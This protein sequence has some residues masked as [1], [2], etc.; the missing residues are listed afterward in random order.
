MAMKAFSSKTLRV[1]GILT[2]IIIIA[3]FLLFPVFSVLISGFKDLSGF[4]EIFSN[5]LYLQIFAFTIG[6]ALLSTLITLIIGIPIGYIFGKYN[7]R[8]RKFFLTLFTVPFI[9]PSV[10]VGMGFLVMFGSEGLFNVPLLSIILAHAFYNIPL[11]VQYFSAYY[12]NFNRS[13]VDAA[14]TLGSNSFNTMMRIYLPIFLQPILT[15]AFL[16][17]NFSFLSFGVIQLLSAGKIATIETLIYSNF[18]NFGVSYAA[19]LAILQLLVVLAYIVIYLL[20]MRTNVGKEKA[21]TTEVQPREQLN[22]KKFFKKYTG[23]LLGGAFLFG[24]I[25]ELAPMVSILVYAF[26][27]P[28]TNNFTFNNFASIFSLT[29]VDLVGASIPRT[30]LNTF[31]FAIGGSLIATIFA[32]ITVASLGKQRRAKK[33]VSIEMITYIPLAIS[34]V[35]LSFGILQTFIGSNL[36]RSHPWIFIIISHGLIGY[37]FVTRALMNGLNSIDPEIIESARTLGAKW[38]YK[39]RK[40]YLPLLLP[41]FIAGLAFAFGL[42][43]GE[44]TIANFFARSFSDS[45][46]STLTV[47]LFVLK[48]NRHLGHP[49]AIGAILLVLSYASFFLIE[50]LGGREKTSSSKAITKLKN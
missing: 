46:L 3:L 33:S 39:L 2:P 9:L 37:P 26:L 31:L 20:L 43:L 1:V 44:F 41:S 12:Q 38:F 14:K 42:S 19:A 4:T 28:Y 50:L 49:R 29:E 34:S 6:Q 24:L 32:I 8:G 13:L 36:F 21:V 30:I 15:A 18:N 16:T 35:T 7:F 11:V 27:E 25:L 48:G 10:L 47:A 40:I 17:F 45:S 22:L 23:Y 5:V